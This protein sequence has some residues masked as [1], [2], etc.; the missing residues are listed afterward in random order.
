M[1]YLLNLQIIY[2]RIQAVDPETELVPSS[3][4]PGLKGI[5]FYEGKTE[6]K[7]FLVVCSRSRGKQLPDGGSLLLVGDWSEEER[8]GLTGYILKKDGDFFS[9]LNMLEQMFFYYREIEKRLRQI[10][11]VDSSL[12]D[13]CQIILEHFGRSVFVHDE[14][15]IFYPVRG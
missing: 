8:A 6:E 2:E 12:N 7:E 10:L 13:I 15:S 9:L 3:R 4:M 1:E 14:H 5:C 11:Y